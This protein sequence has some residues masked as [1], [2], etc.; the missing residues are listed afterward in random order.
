MTAQTAEHQRLRAYHQR[1]SNWKNWGPY[2]SER[3]WGT[4]REDYSEHGEAWDYFPHDHA[5]SRAYR[6][7]ED[8]L[9]GISDRHQYLCFALALWNGRDSILKERLFGLTGPEG[10][11][12]EDVKEYYFYL[13]STPTHSYM[14]MLY[15][16]PQV[17]FPYG[18]LVAE[19][20]RRG[21][22][23]F[24]YELLDTGVFA[25]NRYF[26]V[27]VEYAKADENDILIQIS[28]TNRGPEAAAC[29][30]LPTLWYRNTWSWGYKAGPMG[31]V[32]GKP[33]LRQIAG[34]G[35]FLA[36]Q[37]DHPA[38]GRYFLYAE[39]ASDLLFTENETNAKRLYGQ[40]NETPYKKDSFH[41]YLIN[42]E[43]EAVNP[44]KTGT[45]AAALY[46]E[47]IPAGETHTIRL[48][49]SNK[50]HQSPFRGFS[51]TLKKRQTEA[52][53]F[54]QAIQNPALRE[55]EKRVQRQAFA[56]MLWSKQMYY[57][58]IEQWLNGDPAFPPPPESRKNGRNRDWE[59]LNNFDIISMPDKWEYPWY[60]AWDLAF[61]CI[62][63]VLVDADFAKRQLKL[64]TREW[65]M[66]PNGQ[67]PAYEWAFG[68]VNPPVHAW[69]AWRVY[70][71]DAKQQGRPDTAFLKGIYHKLLLNFTWWV[72]RKDTDGNNIFQG[73]F[74][75]LDNI[76]LFDRSAVLPT[77][78]HLDQSDGTA[79]M[80]FYCLGMMKIALELAKTDPVY[81]DLAT[82][83]YEHSLR[84][85]HA[86]TNC[87]GR[88]HCLWD[89]DDDFFYDALHLPDD[90]IVPLKVRSLVGLIPLLAVE[91]L[92]ADLLEQMPDFKR[93]MHWFTQNRPHLSGN[94]ASIGVE[95]KGRRHLVAFLTRQRLHSVLRYLLDEKEFLSPYGIR[96]LSKIHQTQP[97][98]LSLNGATFTIDYQP[99]ESQSSLFG[100]NSNWRGPVWFPLNYL[101]IESLQKFYHYY[102]DDF[103]VEF[104]T[105]SGVMFTLNQVATELSRRLIRLFLPDENGRRPVYGG[106]APFQEDPHWRDLIL[107]NEY[108]HGD[109]GA[110]L[111][112]SHQ[113]GWTGLVAKLIQQS[114]GAAQANREKETQKK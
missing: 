67:L 83:F 41:R 108:F 105:G 95:G 51:Q 75:G 36:L 84:I 87:G 78:G 45:K 99:A 68:D 104:P 2:L 24:E 100:G 28:V 97:Y 96:S 81:Q 69:A 27:L 110:G 7:N 10:N 101:I 44:D 20:G 55:D 107:F 9:A 64:M 82:K 30:T 42:G 16:Y 73:G 3:A 33:T 34:T 54:Y 66:H 77:G 72:N 31:D 85:A 17:E 8:G 65:Y 109:N 25:E 4:V 26:D 114:G 76:S 86:M 71:I 57:Y 40:N 35:K 90:S 52:D 50:E 21:T 22:N 70:Q 15:K 48:R 18:D 37:G 88:G 38:Q 58:D 59:H 102:G 62:P 112:A 60:A 113:T 74:L 47:I 32:P 6:W 61:H 43:T 106:L 14:K 12:G 19:N 23:D 89:A 5:R 63:L 13:D 46:S 92:E 11:H 49:L 103:K 39:G 93:R 56:G 94:M 111:G 79:W 1:Q 91:T 53:D 80:G 29:H 98:R